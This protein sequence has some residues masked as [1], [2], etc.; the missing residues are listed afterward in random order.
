MKK[1]FFVLIALFTAVLLPSQEVSP[2]AMNYR[3]LEEVQALNPNNPTLRG[4]D[5]RYQGVRGTPL[6]WEDWKPAAI[7]FAGRD[8]FSPE[9]QVNLDLFDQYLFFRLKT[10][11]IGQLK[12]DKITAVK[13]AGEPGGDDMLFKT[14]PE[15]QIEGG[16]SD[17]PAFYQ[18]IYDHTFVLLKSVRKTF[19]KADYEGPFSADRRYDEYLEKVTYW[20]KEKDGPFTK[21]NLNKKSL[22]KALPEQVVNIKRLWKQDDDEKAI[23]DLLKELEGN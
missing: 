17:A 11:A 1:I 3:Y 4:F 15:R 18:V 2:N 6:L 19:R 20:I 7:I 10:G 8:S 12:A 13:F 5:Y 22:A 23:V 21:L 9:V 14:F 16:K